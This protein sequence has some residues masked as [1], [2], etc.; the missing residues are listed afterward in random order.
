MRST[1]I[2]GATGNIGK[3]VLRH[4]PP[5]P[6]VYTA[7]F[8]QPPGDPHKR[9]LDFTKPETLP[10]ALE[11]MHTVFLLRPPQLSDVPRYFEPFMRAAA[12]AAVRHIVFLSVQGAEHVSF[13]PHAKI[14]KL[15]KK[16]GIAYTFVRPGYFMDNLTTTL[17]ADIRDHDRIVLPA[18]KAPFRWTDVNDIGAGIAKI[19]QDPTTHAG[20]AYTFTGPDLIAFPEVCRMLGETRGRPV[21]F[22]SPGPLRYFFAERKRTGKGDLALVKTVLHYLPRWQSPPAY[23]PELA[24][25][26]GHPASTLKAFMERHRK[27]WMV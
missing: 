23:S 11:G 5:A 10:A 17:L 24:D 15:I 8:T 19:L 22:L 13:I 26:L 18:G 16:S 14:E 20:R 9:L 1:L 4:L 12:A 2:T 27:E 25:I 6:E 7:H 3:A 21:H